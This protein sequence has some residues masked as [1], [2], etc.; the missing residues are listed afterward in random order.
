MLRLAIIAFIAGAALV[1]VVDRISHARLL[2]QNARAACPAD[3]APHVVRTDA[4]G[5][6]WTSFGNGSGVISV[7][8]DTGASMTMLTTADAVKLGLKPTDSARSRV[9]FSTVSGEIMVELDRLTSVR[10]GT[11][12]LPLV[13]VA[14]LPA[15]GAQHS[16]LGTNVLRKLARVELSNG[17][18]TLVP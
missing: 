9:R 18:L 6:A 11:L 14:I 2:M 16:L 10:L 5:Q 13:D 3:A 1:T 7:L 4:H 17:R 8:V 15:D 12:C